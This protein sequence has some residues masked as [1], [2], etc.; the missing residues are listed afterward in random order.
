M[1]LI[2]KKQ[3]EL[4]ILVISIMSIIC[5]II[6]FGYCIIYIQTVSIIMDVKKNL[7]YI[8]QNGIIANNKESLALNVYDN[9]DDEIKKYVEQVLNKTYIK[10]STGI[11]K[12]EINECNF[13][14]N[15]EVVKKHT[16]NRY[17][18]P[19]IHINITVY[20]KSIINIQNSSNI[21]QIKIHE[22]IRVALL[23]YEG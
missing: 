11:I 9:N 22:D 3:G 16:N 7:Y 6:L 10:G 4:S 17:N 5:I 20:F 12:F 15:T 19:I 21:L 18:T 1:D 2:L 8:V 13:I 14:A 23:Q